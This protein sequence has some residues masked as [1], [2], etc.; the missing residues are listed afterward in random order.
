MSRAASDVPVSAADVD[1]DDAARTTRAGADADEAA[2][3][4]IVFRRATTAV[5]EASASMVRGLR[6][7]VWRRDDDAR[8]G[9]RDAREGEDRAKTLDANARGS[10][11]AKAF[12]ANATM[13]KMASYDWLSSGTGALLCAGFFHWRGQSVG[14]ALGVACVATIASVVIEELL[15][16][17][18]QPW[19]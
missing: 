15:E 3:A 11:G 2:L 19:V 16:D 5:V 4:T 12:D 13:R 17:R 18:D 6:V 1:V 14:T 8:A 9:E 10:D 7:R